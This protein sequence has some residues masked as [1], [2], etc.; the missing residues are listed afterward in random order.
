[1]FRKSILL[2]LII[3]CFSCTQDNSFTDDKGQEIFT[4]LKPNQTGINFRNDLPVNDTMN[5]FSYGYYYMGGG[6]AIADFDDNGLADVF[7]TG[8][9]ASNALLSLIHISEPTRPY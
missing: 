8:N 4:V 6:V 5:Y 9:V 2:Y 7:F 1:M 3:V